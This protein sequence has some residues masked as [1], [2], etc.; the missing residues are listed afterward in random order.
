MEEVGFELIKIAKQD[1]KYK[2]TKR[3]NRE[4]EV[5]GSGK[6]TMKTIF[7]NNGKPSFECEVKPCYGTSYKREDI[8]HLNIV[9]A[10]DPLG[11]QEDHG[12]WILQLERPALTNWWYF[13]KSIVENEEKNFSIIK[14]V[15]PAKR[16]RNSPEEKPVFHIYTSSKDRD[17]VGKYLIELLEADIE[18]QHR[19]RLGGSGMVETLFWNDG[20][21]AYENA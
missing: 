4:L 15:C 13:L 14:V 2:N 6:V 20:E 7:W 19:C 12:R 11:S 9:T 21:P 18:Y 1:I 16:V 5:A 3:T 8:W 10:P 17:E